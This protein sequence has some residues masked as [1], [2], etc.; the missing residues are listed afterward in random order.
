MYITWWCPWV[1]TGVKILFDPHVLRERKGAQPGDARRR[2]W[3]AWRSSSLDKRPSAG[4]Y[5]EFA[6]ALLARAD[7]PLLCAL[8]PV[9]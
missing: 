7:A 1:V 4:L 6:L 9:R 5:V 8:L 3:Q 2:L